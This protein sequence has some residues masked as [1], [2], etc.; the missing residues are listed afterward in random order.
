MSGLC[1]GCEA[2]DR[3]D[4]IVDRWFYPC[5]L[6]AISSK[7]YIENQTCEKSSVPHIY[8]VLCLERAIWADSVNRRNYSGD[9][10]YCALYKG[11]E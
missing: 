2:H 10:T 11:A 8:L 4:T 9:Y 6:T 5:G 3:V 7:V 1:V